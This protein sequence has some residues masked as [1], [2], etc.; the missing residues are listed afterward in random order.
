MNAPNPLLK[1][2]TFA[3]IHFTVAFAVGYALTGS[4]IVGGAIALVEP[5]V[6]TVAFYLHEKVWSRLALQRARRGARS[7]LTPAPS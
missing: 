7:R 6:N 1:T 2:A 4:V 5:L 3:A